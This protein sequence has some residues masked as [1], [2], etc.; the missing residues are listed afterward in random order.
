MAKKTRFDTVSDASYF[1]GLLSIW[2]SIKSYDQIEKYGK[3]LGVKEDAILPGYIYFVDTW[4]RAFLDEIKTCNYIPLKDNYELYRANHKGIPISEI[5]NSCEKIIFIRNYYKLMQE[6]K[7]SKNK[8]QLEKVIAKLDDFIV[9]F[10]SELNNV[11]YENKDTPLLKEER[12]F[13]STLSRGLFLFNQFNNVTPQGR[14]FSLFRNGSTKEELEK[15][16]EGYKITLLF[17]WNQCLSK[18]QFK[19]VKGIK[20]AIDW[21]REYYA[22]KYMQTHPKK[23][24]RKEDELFPELSINIP[25]N[26]IDCFFRKILDEIIEPLEKNKNTKLAFDTFFLFN[27]KMTKDIFKI[28]L[29]KINPKLTDNNII[30]ELFLWYSSEVIDSAKRNIF[31]GAAAFITVLEGAVRW[32]ERIR[33]SSKVQVL[34][35]PHK[36]GKNQYNYSYGVLIE[37]RGS[38]GSDWSGWMM[39]YDICGDYSGFSGQEHAYV[40]S[41]IKLHL[42]NKSILLRR[43]EIPQKTLK[44]YL[45]KS[46]TERR[47]GQISNEHK[48]RE[49]IL[50]EARGMIVELLVYYL[51]TQIKEQD[52][53]WGF[54]NRKDGDIDILIEKED[55]IKF[56]ECKLNPASCNLDDELKKIKKKRDNHQSSKEKFIE[57]WFWFT[58][59]PKTIKK[60]ESEKIEYHI[61]SKELSN[62]PNFQKRSEKLNLIL[63]SHEREFEIGNE[64]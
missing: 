21:N 63:N 18:D 12:I 15:S 46:S 32:S 9:K 20:D 34:K 27:K 33:D 54:E 42:K 1:V 48:R 31:N 55:N 64:L 19:Y 39:F 57:F 43:K 36:V 25:G 7:K 8:L 6:L 24:K 35:I 26:T 60:L 38:L 37:S 22:H 62:L 29:K 30:D 13:F 45:S 4:L 50:N 11:I 3:T 47:I 23:F 56:I 16:F 49:E 28:F 10:E 51:Q 14:Y 2:N 41:M 52:V 5:S 61:V 44:D 58:P 17:M 59:P 53:K 40:E